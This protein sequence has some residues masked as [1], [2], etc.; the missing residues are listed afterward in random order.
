M[1]FRAAAA[2]CWLVPTVLGAQEPA[3]RWAVQLR[4]A[5]G[6]E[7]ADLR[8]DGARSRIL[9]ESHDSLFFPLTKLQRTGNHLSFAVGALGLRAELDVDGDG[10]A[11]SGR[12]RY[13]DGGGASWEGE[14]IR[15]GTARWPVRPRVRVRQLAVGTGAN[16]TVIPA[17]WVAALPDSM[18]LEREYAELLR[19]TGLPVVRDRERADRS[20]AMALGADEATRASVRR[21]LAAIAASPAADSTFRRLFVG[22]AGVIIDLHERAEA[23]AMARSRGGYQPG[24][25]ARGLR[26]LGVLD[27][28]TANDVGRMRAA[29]LASWPAWFRHDSTMA[30][31]MAALDASDPEARRELNLLFECYL[32]AVPWWREAVQWLLDHPWIDTPMGPRA[33][34]QLMAKVW[35]RAS[36]VP[37]VLLPEPLG[38]FAAMPLVNG[39]RL[40]RTLVEPANAAARE[41]LPAGRVEAITAWSALTWSDTLTL[42]AAGGDIALLPPSRVPGLQTL[43]ATADGVRIDPGIMPLL[44]VATV[45]HEWHHMLAC[46]TRLEGQ[47]V[48]RTRSDT[49]SACSRTTLAWRGLRGVGH[50]GDVSS[51]RCVTALPL[52]TLVDFEK[53]MALHDGM[54][55]DPHAL[56][57]RLVRAAAA[58][59]P[60]ATR[61]D[62]PSWH[63]FT[64]PVPWRASLTL[65]TARGRAT[66]VATA[67]DGRDRAGDHPDLGCRRGRSAVARV[68]CF[69]H[70]PRS[71][72]G[73]PA[74][75][76]RWCRPSG[77]HAT[78]C[79]ADCS[80]SAPPASRTSS[81]AEVLAFLDSL[82]HQGAAI[83]VGTLGESPQGRRIPY[84][85]AA[86]P[87]VAD[88]AEAKRSGKPVFY[89]QGNIHAGEVEGKEAV[90][91]LLRDM[92]LGPLTRAA[93]QR[94][95]GLGADLQHRRQRRLR[96]RGPQPSGAERPAD[97]RPARQRAGARPQP[98]LRQAGGTG[99]ARFAGADRGVGPRC[100]DGPA[101]HQRLVSRLC[102]DVGARAQSES[103]TGQHLVAGQGAA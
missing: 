50:R 27:A 38:G 46:R 78:R 62:V 36:L 91:R 20:R 22:P 3:T 2:A 67:G 76:A 57:Y 97:R 33:P 35:G 16:A 48:S 81:H 30:R 47:G 64:M 85:V 87:M 73:S 9:L 1:T 74:F 32:D 94:D 103:D 29:A 82:A 52:L 41:W 14:L 54:S 90:Q 42:S 95:R 58:R 96:S 80:R 5:A 13:P 28:N 60:V 10:A 7:F 65:P 40:A 49:S 21:T 11:M 23:L 84:V 68:S 101:H 77:R 51:R 39:D 79:A 25:A 34:A 92:T 102:P 70:Y 31:A 45:I 61:R 6:V 43:L 56:G 15:P 18:T 26:R 12:L 83:R 37:P 53:R 72:D 100:L 75:L 88:P 63:G 24:A 44:A 93:R 8:L 55:E 99:D 66:T 86:R 4:T 69:L 89:I 19:R 17:A 71:T 59:L 98:R